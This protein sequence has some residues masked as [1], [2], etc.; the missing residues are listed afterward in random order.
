M[1]TYPVVTYRRSPAAAGWV[2]RN[3][4][5]EEW[6]GPFASRDEAV[7]FALEAMTRTGTAVLAKPSVRRAA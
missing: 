7:T 5:E 6:H 1:R 4:G 2:F 3:A